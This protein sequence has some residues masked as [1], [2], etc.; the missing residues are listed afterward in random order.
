MEN[1]QVTDIRIGWLIGIIEGE[2]SI[3]MGMS[4]VGKRVQYMPRVTI[5]NTDPGIIW[6]AT[7]VLEALGCGYHIV[8]RDAGNGHYGDRTLWD[9]IVC[10][11]VSLEKLLK[12]ITPWLCGSKKARA[13]LVLSF[14]CKRIPKIQNGTNKDRAYMPDEILDAERIRNFNDRT[15]DS[16]YTEKIQSVL[17]GK[18]AERGRNDHAPTSTCVCI[19]EGVTKS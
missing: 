6:E 3:I 15:R 16:E 5:T 10:R 13:M 19:E 17:Q 12:A 8:Q 7:Q 9:L 18:L 1:P 11:L 2:G 4:R 14:V